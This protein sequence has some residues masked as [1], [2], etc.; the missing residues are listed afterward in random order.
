[1]V[2]TPF[3]GCQFNSGTTFNRAFLTLISLKFFFSIL[4]CLPRN[5]FLEKYMAWIRFLCLQLYCIYCICYF[6]GFC[7]FV[8][9]LNVILPFCLVFFLTYFYRVASPRLAFMLLWW[10]PYIEFFNSIQKHRQLQISFRLLHFHFY[11]IT[12]IS[13]LSARFIE[14]HCYFM[15]FVVRCKTTKS[16]CIH[17]E[18]LNIKYVD[19]Y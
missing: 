7:F 14:I 16:L 6:F 8:F 10:S 5:F 19:Y 9:V 4:K 17:T 13:F 12:Q 2:F 3:Q 1:M 15:L 11:F 18:I